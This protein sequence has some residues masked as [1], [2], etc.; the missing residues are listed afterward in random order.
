MKLKMRHVAL[1]TA[2]A[3]AG[4]PAVAAPS[5]LATL[6]LGRYVVAAG[7]DAVLGNGFIANPRVGA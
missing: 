7:T 5:P 6:S 4:S 2:L 3:L 1:A